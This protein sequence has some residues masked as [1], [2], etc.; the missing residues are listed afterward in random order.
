[1]TTFTVRCPFGC[2]SD[3]LTTTDTD[4]ADRAAVAHAVNT[5]HTTEIVEA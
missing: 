3:I 1:M 2:A 4:R 5:T